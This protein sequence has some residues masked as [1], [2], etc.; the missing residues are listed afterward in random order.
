MA[1]PKYMAGRVLA[2]LGGWF[3]VFVVVC[4]GV[5]FCVVH[6]LDISVI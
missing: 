3:L 1:D 2:F 5:L 6:C 4:F